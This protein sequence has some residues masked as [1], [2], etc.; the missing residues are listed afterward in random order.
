MKSQA[1]KTGQTLDGFTPQQRF[2]VGFGQ[3]WCGSQ[4]DQSA[5]L[6]AFD[7]HPPDKFRVDGTLSNMS[8]FAQA[9]SCKSGDAMV[10]KNP[11]R[12]W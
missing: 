4:T 11:A 12:V 7:P 6:Q 5:R 10:N 8:E 2:F 3:S 1:G 9:F